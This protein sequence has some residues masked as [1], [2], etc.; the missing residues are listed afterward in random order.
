MVEVGSHDDVFV[1]PPKI[2]IVN[3]SS[4][5][6]PSVNVLKDLQDVSVGTAPTAASVTVSTYPRD[7][8]DSLV[9]ALSDRT[10]GLGP[11]LE[12]PSD[13]IVNYQIVAPALPVHAWDRVSHYSD[14]IQK[15]IDWQRA[16][17]KPELV[18]SVERDVET[19]RNKVLMLFEA[20]S[21]ASQFFNS[22]VYRFHDYPPPVS[23]LAKSILA[24]RVAT[25]SF[26]FSSYP[27]PNFFCRSEQPCRYSL[28]NGSSC[29]TFLKGGSPPAGL[30]DHWKSV[31][32]DFE[33]PR[34][35]STIPPDHCVYAYLPVESVDRH[36]N[37]PHVHYHLAGKDALHLM[38]SRTT[39]LL[40]NTKDHR[41]C[42]C[43]TTHSMGS[44]GI[45]VIH[46]DEDEA[47]F[48]QF[49]TESGNPTYVITE[50]VEITRNVACHFFIHP[51]GHLT[52]FGSSE[53]LQHPDGR[54]NSDATI[55]MA[56]QEELRELQLPFVQDVARYCLSLGFWGLCGIDVLFDANGQGYLV[57]LN[58]R[59]TGS[60][61]ALMVA[62][63][64]YHQYGYDFCY[65][66]RKTKMAYRGTAERLLADVDEY[67]RSQ[68]GSSCI[69]LTAFF[70]LPLE[71]DATMGPRTRVEMAVYANSSLEECQQVLDRFTKPDAAP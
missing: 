3:Q 4:S 1:P 44:K 50:F 53:N 7:D 23:P 32:P 38:T 65:Y 30:V 9:S 6:I 36:V 57:D 37:D 14:L 15:G 52:W 71:E 31:V 42:I 26:V 45:F 19:D 33:E 43:K 48:L 70:E 21:S 35:E 46:N 28:M 16:H 24:V 56:D 54:W 40:T 25:F 11:V 69:V 63:R 62:Q 27:L 2:V 8:N 22:Q 47:S 10:G 64:L 51:S 66:R 59:V 67:N 18:A 49:L 29:P 68:A 60:C 5:A 34:Y 20:P 12:N 17:G 55:V 41:P 61:P 58:P 39:K 13:V